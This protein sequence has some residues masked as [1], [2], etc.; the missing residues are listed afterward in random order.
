MKGLHRANYSRSR[1]EKKAWDYKPASDWVFT[2][3]DAIIDE[4]TFDRVNDFLT[5]QRK[6]KKKIARIPVKHLFTGFVECSCSGKMYIPSKSLAYV[7][8]KCHKQ[9]DKND[10]ESIYIEHLKEFLVS[11]EEIEK[12]VLEANEAFQN[13]TR[14][15]QLLESE[16]KKVK[17]EMD[18]L[19]DLYISDSIG[20]PGF[21]RKHRPLEERL[22]QIDT[23]IPNLQGMVD[24]IKQTNL[25]SQQI[26]EETGRLFQRWD[27]LKKD[28]KMKIIETI[29]EKIIVSDNEVELQLHYLPFTNK[30]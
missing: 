4:D 14:E 30:I 6:S 23:Q 19:Y 12:Y 1:G 25:S 20:K 13:K 16:R 27:K 8:R 28:E 29:T 5:T 7:C 10:L 11:K 3:V 17:N 21:E 24:A 2:R 22:I 15:L 18:K 26:T 9:I